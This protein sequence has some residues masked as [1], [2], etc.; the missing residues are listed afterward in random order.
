MNA[1]LGL[2]FGFALERCPRRE[3]L[4]AAFSLWPRIMVTRS[5][6][7]TARHRQQPLG[8]VAQRPATA[9]RIREEPSLLRVTEVASDNCRNLVAQEFTGQPTRAARE[10]LFFWA[11]GFSKYARAAILPTTGV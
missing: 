6:A 7:E 8:T 10:F 4:G 5:V 9:A 11:S 1:L 2:G 3:L